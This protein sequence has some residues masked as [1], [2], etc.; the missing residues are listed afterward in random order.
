VELREFLGRIPIQNQVVVPAMLLPNPWRGDYTTIVFKYF[1]LIVNLNRMI[2]VVVFVETFPLEQYGILRTHSSGD[3][4]GKKWLYQLL[5][6][7]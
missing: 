4:F 7:V 5:I 2:P 3:D 6:N 1:M